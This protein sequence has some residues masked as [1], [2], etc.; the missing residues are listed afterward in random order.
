MGFKPGAILANALMR[1]RQVTELRVLFADKPGFGAFRVFAH[2]APLERMNA[3]MA[4]DL[5]HALNAI[6]YRVLTRRAEMGWGVAYDA[7]WAGG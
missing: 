4:R 7:L 3:V 5:H 2:G 1:K 6:A